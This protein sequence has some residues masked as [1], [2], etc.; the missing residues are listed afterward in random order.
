MILFLFL[1]L[2]FSFDLE[3]IS[4]TSASC[5]IGVS[6]HLK[7]VKALGLRPLAFICFRVFGNLNETLT[8]VFEILLTG[9][10]TVC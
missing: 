5:F 6:K 7:T 2:N 8:L 9:G 4:K 10:L 1:L 3:A